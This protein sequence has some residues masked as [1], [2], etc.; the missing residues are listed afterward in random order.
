MHH[1]TCLIMSRHTCS[2]NIDVNT[3][4]KVFNMWLN[5]FKSKFTTWHL[6]SPQSAIRFISKMLSWTKTATPESLRHSVESA[7]YHLSIKLR[8]PW[9]QTAVNTRVLPIH[10]MVSSTDLFTLR[11]DFCAAKKQN[12]YCF[13]F[14]Q[15][16]RKHLKRKL[17]F[18]WW[19]PLKRNRL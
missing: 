9:N 11:P 3:I 5:P 2:H 13:C 14:G 16:W 7:R 4:S 10:K 15:N 12:K 1:E 6:P 17:G 8:L 18:V 19:F